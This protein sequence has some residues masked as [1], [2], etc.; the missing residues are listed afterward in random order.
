MT[1]QSHWIYFKF[2]EY[3]AIIKSLYQVNHYHLHKKTKKKLKKLV[4]T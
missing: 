4:T 2:V 1:L 3:N